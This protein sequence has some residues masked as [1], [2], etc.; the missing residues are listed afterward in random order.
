[1]RGNAKVLEQLNQALRDELTAII[2]GILAGDSSEASTPAL[3]MI[4][5]LALGTKA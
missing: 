5:S 2:E 4:F 3:S 1:M